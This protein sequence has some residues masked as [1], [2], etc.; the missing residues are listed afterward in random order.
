MKEKLSRELTAAY[1]TI[2]ILKSINNDREATIKD[3]ENEI[4]KSKEAAATLNHA[5]N[6]NRI[7]FENEKLELFKEHQKEIKSWRRQ[8]GNMTTKHI[9]LERKF[10]KLNAEDESLTKNVVQQ[11]DA[12][13]IE[14]ITYAEPSYPS[15]LQ[16]RCTL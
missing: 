7:K 10:A 8:L 14:D 5:Y 13:S 3:L 11:V 15:A 4:I 2:K 6:N 16:I 9:N 1:E 12:I